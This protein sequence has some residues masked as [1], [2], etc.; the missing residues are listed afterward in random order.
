M[1]ITIVA[2]YVHGI[3]RNIRAYNIMMYL[4]II[5]L[6]VRAYNTRREKKALYTL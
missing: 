4:Y 5:L 3:T 6:W 1:C 2:H